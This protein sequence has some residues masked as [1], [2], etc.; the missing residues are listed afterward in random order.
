MFVRTLRKAVLERA[1]VSS[2]DT[3]RQSPFTSIGDPEALFPKREL[4]DLLHLAQSLA[5]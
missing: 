4:D 3:L 5:A 2:L 1:E